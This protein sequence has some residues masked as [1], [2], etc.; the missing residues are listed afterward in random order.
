MKCVRVKGSVHLAFR[1]RLVALALALALVAMVAAATAAI[2][3]CKLLEVWSEA[4]SLGTVSA[5]DADMTLP[6]SA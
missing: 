1:L 4:L 3:P 5:A 6:L 2:M